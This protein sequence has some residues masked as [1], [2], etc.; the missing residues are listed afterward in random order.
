MSDNLDYIAV[1]FDK[2]YHED[3]Y[4]KYIPGYIG[5]E[6]S[7][8]F[9][10]FM[11][12]EIYFTSYIDTNGQ[13]NR[14]T[15]FGKYLY[16]LAGHT[17]C[18]KWLEIGT[19]N[20][21]GTTSCI[22]DGFRDSNKIDG[23]LISYEANPTMYKIA[24]ENM[25]DHECSSQLTIHNGRP[26]S[27]KSFPLINDLDDGSFYFRTYYDTERYLYTEA[28]EI[29]PVYAPEGIVL[30]GAEYTGMIDW[31]SIPKQNLKIIFL[32]D[33]NVKKNNNVLEML[34]KD[35]LWILHKRGDERNGW[36][37]FLRR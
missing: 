4:L 14:N 11:K 3:R 37:C 26:L 32:D 2:A 8:R 17:D 24:K 6:N 35:P 16:F 34:M 27:G 21:K 10:I 36:A 29:E 30:D 25:K 9:V 18:N 13:I 19:W 31:E 23:Y 28:K 7:T 33:V 20:G 5:L 1:L 22:L 15:D 12:E